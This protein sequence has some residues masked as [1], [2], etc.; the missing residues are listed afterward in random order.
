[1]NSRRRGKRFQFSIWSLLVLMTVTAVVLSIR[2]YAP[3]PVDFVLSTALWYLIVLG[4]GL[5]LGR[6]I[7]GLIR[8][9]FKLLRLERFSAY[10]FVARRILGP[11][12]RSFM[13]PGLAANHLALAL[14]GDGQ[15]DKAIVQ[16]DRAI[17]LEGRRAAIPYSNRG[18]AWYLKGEY[19]RAIGDYDS[20]LRRNSR[21][22]LTYGLRALALIAKGEYDRAID[23]CDASIHCN[24]SQADAYR[25]RGIAYAKQGFWDQAL[26]D[27]DT[28]IARNPASLDAYRFRAAAWFLKNQPVMAIAD[29][30]HVLRRDP[31]CAD[32]LRL[33]GILSS[34]EGR[35]ESAMK[36]LDRAIQLQQ[37]LP[38]A[39]EARGFAWDQVGEYRRAI[40]DY[41]EA[42]R[43]CPENAQTLSNRG[44]S[45]FRMGDDTRALADFADA[46]RLDPACHLVYNN[47]G[48]LHLIRGQYE[49]AQLDLQKAIE[50]AP[51]HPNAHKN[52][53][54]LMATCPNAG[55]RDGAKALEHARMALELAGQTDPAWLDILAAAYGGTG[56]FDAAVAWEMKAIEKTEDPQE[57]SDYERRL[58]LYRQRRP[59]RATPSPATE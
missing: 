44:L 13:R 42:L 34:R 20:A 35:I 41:D 47:R 55:F 12:R 25:Y 50:L 36:D 56:D 43:L 31:N 54:W 58:E 29:I 24:S 14:I 10:R 15:L 11:F 16:L 49:Q 19:D 21:L 32:M 6:G 7:V 53:A 38:L 45:H 28:A 39:Y 4:A 18:Y 52:L 23:D 22:A 30:E 1:M 27:L 46:I 59:Y 3:E 33:R 57:L 2:H 48:Y 17:E 8:P 9:I 40:A 26:L 51:K 37:E 5:L